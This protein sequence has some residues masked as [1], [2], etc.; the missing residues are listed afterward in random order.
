MFELLGC[1]IVVE[2]DNFSPVI[3]VE[4]S[5]NPFAI[6]IV[7][8]KLSAQPRNLKQAMKVA[9]ELKKRGMN[10]SLGLSQVN[11]INFATYKI[12]HTNAFSVCENLLAGSQ[13]LLACYNQYKTWNKAYSCYYTGN[14]TLGVKLGYVAKVNKQRTKPN[15]KAVQEPT[16][17]SQDIKIIAY[18]SSPAKKKLTLFERRLNS[19]IRTPTS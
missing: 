14:D 19:K 13:I 5:G 3:R 9:D 4:S 15:I 6:G 16:S 7:G 17:A 10:Y 11:K 1:P 2:P 12:N 18:S 8:H